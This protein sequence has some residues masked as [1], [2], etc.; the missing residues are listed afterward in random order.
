MV[1]ESLQ[2]PQGTE[3]QSQSPR[4]KYSPIVRIPAST[5]AKIR[6]LYLVRGHSPK[7]IAPQVN[8]TTRQVSNWLNRAG[9]TKSKRMM[10]ERNKADLEALQQEASA[11]ATEAL[12]SEVEDIV[13]EGVE[14]VRESVRERDAKAFALS[15]QG[16]R[17][18]N[19]V[20]R[21]CR[22][23]ISP[24]QSAPRSL[25]LFFLSGGAPPKLVTEMP[26]PANP[27]ALQPISP[28]G[29]GQGSTGAPPSA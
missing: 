5:Q 21:D 4:N 25:N 7:E 22:R 2:A 24:E 16:V 12:A 18:M 3:I 14:M 10:L 23:P 29:E 20:A 11:R 6:A 8:L 27:A 15:S 19:S 28:S 9:L 13:W 1:A 17:N 26:I